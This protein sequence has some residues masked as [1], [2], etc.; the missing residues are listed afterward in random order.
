MK[1]GEHFVVL[2]FV[3]FDDVLEIENLVFPYP[4]TKGNFADSLHSGYAMFGLRSSLDG[5]LIAYAVVMP[6]VDEL[7]LL[8]V[9]VHAAQQGQ[10]YGRWM[11]DQLCDY[12]HDQGHTS[13]LLEV[14][15]SNSAAI[16]LYS[17]YGFAEIGRRKSYYPAANGTREDAVVMRLPL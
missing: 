11:L 8:N 13:L 6:V 12:A 5:E 14:R 10:G 9:A 15:V 16:K 7:H 17:R 1:D 2:R 4:W 3:D